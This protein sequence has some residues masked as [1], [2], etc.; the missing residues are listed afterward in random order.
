MSR[1]DSRGPCDIRPARVARG[2]LPNCAGSASAQIGATTAFC[3]IIGP[4]QGTVDSSL[5]P[6]T[7][8]SCTV[9]RA[10]FAKLVIDEDYRESDR[11]LSTALRGALET[12]LSPTE[13][14]YL[15]FDVVVH[16]VS[17]DGAD[18]MCAFVAAMVALLDAGIA[19]DD[20]ALAARVV[21]ITQTN[22][23]GSTATQLVVDPG[24][25]ELRD[26]VV[27]SDMTVVF[28]SASGA[29][30]HMRSVAFS[31]VEAQT[32]AMDLGLLAVR[33]Q[34]ANLLKQVVAV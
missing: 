26:A 29:V 16:I 22:E 17:S 10:S 11:R 6:R 28:A 23:D 2:I 19:C 4:S 31:S 1:C 24:P 34:R 21:S 33:A 12:V 32:A 14:S 30:L 9:A 5:G 20:V 3:S 13:H 18:D 7:R 15:Q 25:T 27:K 8:L